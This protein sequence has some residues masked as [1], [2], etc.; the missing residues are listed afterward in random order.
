M[1]NLVRSWSALPMSHCQHGAGRVPGYSS[2]FTFFI[3]ELIHS[4]GPI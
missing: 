3:A 4:L 1:R 2:R